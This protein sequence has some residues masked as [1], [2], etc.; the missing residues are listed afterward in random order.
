M[1]SA[2]VILFAF[3]I[4]MNQACKPKRPAA[5]SLGALDSPEASFSNQACSAAT[6]MARVSRISLGGRTL[7]VVQEDYCASQ[8]QAYSLGGKTAGAR[9]SKPVYIHYGYYGNDPGDQLI[10]D[11]RKSALAWARDNN[12]RVVDVSGMDISRAQRT[13]IADRAKNPRDYGPSSYVM[14]D[15]DAHGMRT[16]NSHIIARQDNS[17]NVS[18]T[19]SYR[20]TDVQRA[21]LEGVGNK[22]GNVTSILQACFGGAATE[23]PQ[24]KDIEKNKANPRQQR[25]FLFGAGPNTV[26]GTTGNL[27]DGTFD[28]T[29]N[30]GIEQATLLLMQSADRKKGLTVGEFKKTLASKNLFHPELQVETYFNGSAGVSDVDPTGLDSVS[31]LGAS[32][33]NHGSQSPV[34]VGP[35][36]AMILPPGVGPIKGF[37]P[38]HGKDET[39]EDF[40]RWTP[41]AGTIKEGGGVQDK[42]ADADGVSSD[43][44]LDP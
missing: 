5:S 18:T 12:F 2:S 42:P 4:V 28:G 29:P 38:V 14:I 7:M 23:D 26:A 40:K 3:L 21:L 37:A 34:V 27:Q 43:T 36:Q 20:T 15:V 41:P 33:W 1:R 10:A 30:P 17:R 22:A 39:S 19:T 8:K 9:A 16:A 31:H 35:D 11:G 25:V 6:A 13:I 24:F 44:G 32:I